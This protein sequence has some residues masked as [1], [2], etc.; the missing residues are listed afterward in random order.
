MA[1]FFDK[2]H[3][4]RTC[5]AN[6]RRTWPNNIFSAKNMQSNSDKKLAEVFQTSMLTKIRSVMPGIS[7]TAFKP[8]HIYH[9]TLFYHGHGRS[10]EMSDELVHGLSALLKAE[11]GKR[12]FPVRFTHYAFN[13]RICALIAELPEDVFCENVENG[14]L[15]HIT[16]A[17]NSQPVGGGV[18]HAAESVDLLKEVLAGRV[19]KHALSGDGDWFVAA[20]HAP[21]VMHAERVTQ[22][23]WR[24]D[25]NELIAL[26]ES[27][28]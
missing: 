19:E 15:A 2:K 13:D 10:K 24:C 4:R 25:K 16:V 20:D 27:H 14:S 28:F 3:G 18:V 5:R 7:E 12:D 9:V 17:M 22:K 8:Q 11:K 23:G 26:L 21:Q 1:L 6:A